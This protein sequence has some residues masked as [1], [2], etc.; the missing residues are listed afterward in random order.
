[1]CND[2]STGLPENC[3]TT[4]FLEFNDNPHSCLKFWSRSSPFKAVEGECGI[5]IHNCLHAWR[6]KSFPIVECCSRSIRWK[7]VLVFY[8]PQHLHFLEVETSF[9]QHYHRVQPETEGQ[10]LA[11]LVHCV[12]KH[13]KEG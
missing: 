5:S 11:Y 13:I 9:L 8:R 3:I 1:M 7:V 10:R 4:V 6:L 2:V 12:L